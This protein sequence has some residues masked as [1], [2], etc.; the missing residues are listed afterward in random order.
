MEDKYKLMV[1]CF[2]IAAVFVAVGVGLL[3]FAAETFDA[4]AELFGAPEWEVWHPPFPD[5]EIPG[6]EGN[7]AMNF[8]LG[9]GFTAL[10]LLLT[11]IIGWGITRLRSGRQ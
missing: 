10:I 11:F 8:L 2:I 5:Y 4:I 7:L 1:G 3:G 6:F 9:L